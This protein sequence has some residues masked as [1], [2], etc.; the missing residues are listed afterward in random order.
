MN[1]FNKE[2]LHKKINKNLFIWIMVPQKISQNMPAV[3]AMEIGQHGTD[4]SD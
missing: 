1:F 2:L 4:I 3:K